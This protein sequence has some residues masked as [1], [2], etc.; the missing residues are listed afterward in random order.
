MT[1][2][3]SFLGVLIAATA[4]YVGGLMLARKPGKKFREELKKSDHPGKKLFEEIWETKKEGYNEVRD[5]AENSEELKRMK[6]KGKAHID[7]AME[8]AKILGLDAIE[9][10]KKHWESLAEYAKKK[11]EEAK[12]EVKEKGGKFKNHIEKEVKTIAGRE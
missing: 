8:H 4:G 2:K 10:A 7:M 12:T 11:S 6:E 5:W 9:E 3:T 1:K